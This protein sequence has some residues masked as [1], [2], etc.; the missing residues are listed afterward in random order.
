[1]RVA[2][3]G[4]TYPDVQTAA[5]TLGVSPHTIYCA[6]TR[7]NIERVGLG[8]DYRNRVTRGGL[9]PKPV[10]IGGISFK[11]LAD[12]ARYVGL[13]AKALRSRMA[14]GDGPRQRVAR[15]VMEATARAEHKARM[16]RIKGMEAQ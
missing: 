13:P 4:V 8:V 1:M 16:E 10:T 7:G 11:S 14:R 12:L 15:M 5:D 2:I 6:M 9:P 3:R